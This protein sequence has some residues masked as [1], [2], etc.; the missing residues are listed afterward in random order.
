MNSVLYENKSFKT[1]DVSRLADVLCDEW[2]SLAP[3][4]TLSKK[5]AY[6]FKATRISFNG[7][8]R[9]TIDMSKPK[10]ARA[11]Y[12][13][14]LFNLSLSPD[15]DD[16]S[17]H[18]LNT[19]QLMNFMKL[20]PEISGNNPPFIIGKD[21]PWVASGFA[22]AASLGLPL[23][24]ELLQFNS[25]FGFLTSDTYEISGQVLDMK[26]LGIDQYLNR[27]KA[28][29]MA[30]IYDHPERL[31]EAIDAIRKSAKNNDMAKKDLDRI[32]N[33]KSAGSA[34]WLYTKEMIERLCK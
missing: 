9:V 11:G 19:F 34:S 28:Y 5:T 13:T 12:I 26:N 3:E 22:K 29:R 27:V 31:E 8:V 24:K 4:L 18:V 2:S 6:G 21:E 33:N 14:P 25:C 20:F 10:I 1:W 30:Q 7:E 32:C 16:L 15:P 17:F 23:I